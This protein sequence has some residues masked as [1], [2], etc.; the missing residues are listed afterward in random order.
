[1]ENNLLVELAKEEDEL[2]LILEIFNENVPEELH[3]LDKI[4]ILLKCLL[5]G[6]AKKIYAEQNDICLISAELSSRTQ[7]FI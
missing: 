2:Q 1:M 6:T 3:F 7:R 4:Q 5:S